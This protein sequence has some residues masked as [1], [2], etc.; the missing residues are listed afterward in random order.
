M[1]RCFFVCAPLF[2][3]LNSRDRFCHVTTG[4]CLSFAVGCRRPPPPSSDLGFRGDPDA[5]V[6]GARHEV[7]LLVQYSLGFRSI[8]VQ[9]FRFFQACGGGGAV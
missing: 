6:L 7:Y 2:K 3:K 5:T 8:T 4:D 9:E 1:P